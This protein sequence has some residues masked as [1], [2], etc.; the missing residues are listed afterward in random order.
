MNS[1]AQMVDHQHRFIIITVLISLAV[2]MAALIGLTHWNF[3]LHEQPWNSART[4]TVSSVA[5]VGELRVV[6]FTN[7]DTVLIF[8]HSPDGWFVPSLKLNAI[9]YGDVYKTRHT[10]VRYYL[11][12]PDGKAEVR[13]TADDLLVDRQTLITALSA[14]PKPDARP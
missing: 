4:L 14:W 6:S 11:T 9:R 7:T 12:K 8:T 3:N 13:E 1:E 2:M 5:E 10:L